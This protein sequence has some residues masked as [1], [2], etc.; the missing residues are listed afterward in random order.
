MFIQAYVEVTISLS[1]YQEQHT[2]NQTIMAHTW[3]LVS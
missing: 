1:N 3:S 2:V